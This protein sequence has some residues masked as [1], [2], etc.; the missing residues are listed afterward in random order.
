[1]GLGFFPWTGEDLF[2]ERD[3]WLKSGFGAVGT[4]G[5]SD[6]VGAPDEGGMIGAKRGFVDPVY[7]EGVDDARAG[8]LP[9]LDSPLRR[10]V[11]IDWSVSERWAVGGIPMCWNSEARGENVGDARSMKDSRSGLMEDLPGGGEE[12]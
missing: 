6:P 4:G 8:D 9:W 1:M 3:R 11:E 7:E 12:G 10:G 2:A 5:L